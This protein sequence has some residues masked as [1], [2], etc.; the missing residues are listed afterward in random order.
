MLPQVVDA[1]VKSQAV[2]KTIAS[3]FKE[4][5]HAP[6]VVHVVQIARITK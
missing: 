5:Y 3:V 6:L 2:P 4:E 1:A